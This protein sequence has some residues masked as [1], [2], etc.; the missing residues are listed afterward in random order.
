MKDISNFKQEI[1]FYSSYSKTTKHKERS[2]LMNGP[3]DVRIHTCTESLLKHIDRYE[4]SY[5]GMMY[6]SMR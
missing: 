5:R 3:T 2:S 4:C 6:M 1:E